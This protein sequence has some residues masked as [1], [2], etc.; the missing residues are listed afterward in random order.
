MTC[1]DADAAR[2]ELGPS[3]LALADTVCSEEG[4]VVV[5]RDG[6]VDVRAAYCICAAAVLAGCMQSS[7]FDA[8]KPALVKWLLSLQ[9]YEGGFACEVGGEAHGGYT[10]CAV[11]ALALLGELQSA[12]LPELVAWL[13]ARQ[14][15]C[16]GGCSGRTAKLVDGCYSFWVGAT[17]GI[18]HALD[19]VPRGIGMDSAALQTYILTSC[20]TTQ[21]GLRD[22]PGLY[23]THIGLGCNCDKAHAPRLLCSV[24][25]GALTTT[26]RVIVC[27]G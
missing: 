10:Y 26:T 5:H 24:S 7:S 23:V 16:E 13:S 1:A 20:Q 18:L 2:A 22:K 17:A 25:P 21:G 6:E 12:N 14:T 27:L 8:H 3:V 9:T 4:P 19:L 15:R 11:A